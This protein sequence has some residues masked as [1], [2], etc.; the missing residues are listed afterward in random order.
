MKTLE[1]KAPKATDGATKTD[2]RT[3]VLITTHYYQSLI[4][5]ALLYVNHS[6]ESLIT[7]MPTWW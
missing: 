5:K 7:N 6:Y 4:P 1:A 3:W 2:F